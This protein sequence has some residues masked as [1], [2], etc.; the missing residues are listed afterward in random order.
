METTAI[1]TRSVSNDLTLNGALTSLPRILED[2]ATR[3]LSAQYRMGDFTMTEQ[4][5]MV[6][7]QALKMVSGVDLAALYARYDLLQDIERD[8]LFSV[9][10]AHFD[11][12]EEMAKQLGISMSELSNIRDLCGTIFPYIQETLQMSVPEL[13]EEIG[14]SKFR[15][16]V[17]ILKS[18]ITGENS[19]SQATRD[20]VE[21]MLDNVAAGAEVSGE[22]LTQQEMRA[23]AVEQIIDHGRHLPNEAL[24]RQ[25]RP[26]GT[27]PVTPSVITVDNR[28]VVLMDIDEDQW[29]ML[30]RLLRDHMEPSVVALPNDRGRR[31]VEAL[32]IPELRALLDLVQ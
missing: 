14:K 17:P 21:Q 13:W 18:L 6:K 23:R 20:T 31:Q 22:E 2:A 26:N 24:R 10:P 30:Q 19:M 9:H 25:L 7:I 4:V 8:A 15:E 29:N 11:T 1:V 3:A 16:M 5:A 12:F 27:P 32:R 28:K